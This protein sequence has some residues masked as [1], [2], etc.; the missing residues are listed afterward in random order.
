M[1]MIWV[2]GRLRMAW[3]LRPKVVG[4]T[5]AILVVAIFVAAN[6]HFFFVAFQSQPDCIEHVKRGEGGEGKFAA[7]SPA[8]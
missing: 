6:A 2:Q 7:A 1:S 8:C 3:V 5:I 4:V